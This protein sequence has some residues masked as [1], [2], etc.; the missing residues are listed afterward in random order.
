MP[1]AT[2]PGAALLTCPDQYA[3]QHLSALDKTCITVLQPPCCMACTCTDWQA[4]QMSL[5]ASHQPT[6]MYWC[7]VQAC[8]KQSA[9]IH[10]AKLLQQLEMAM[11]MWKI[12]CCCLANGKVSKILAKALQRSICMQ[13]HN[14]TRVAVASLI[15]KVKSDGCRSLRSPSFISLIFWQPLGPCK[16]P[17]C[18]GI[19]ALWQTIQCD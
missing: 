9:A 4:D 5:T 16:L 15:Y 6:S 14:E 2:T 12:D 18:G 1:D 19:I 13:G 7:C 11:A 8:V 3:I 17:H 10:K